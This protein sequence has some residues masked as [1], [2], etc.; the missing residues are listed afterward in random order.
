MKAATL[1]ALAALIGNPIKHIVVLMEENRSFDHLF[2]Y[3]KGSARPVNGLS[4]N[5]FNRLDTGDVTSKKI[6]VDNKAPYVAPCD[7]N[8][9]TPPTT[10]KIF[11]GNATAAGDLSN[12]A[13]L[14]FAEQES[15]AH[16]IDHCAVMSCF[17]PE[18]VPVLSALAE[19]FVLMDHFFA[20]HPGPTWPNRLYTLS[21]TSAGSTSTGSWYQ[22]KVGKL[23]PQ[24]TIFDQVAEAGLTWRNY[25]NDTPWELF[26][27]SLAHNT[28]NIKPL[29][30]F[31]DDARDGTLPSFSWINP[32]SGINTTTGVGSNDHHPDHDVAAGEAFY[33]DIYE[34]LRA[35]AAWNETLFIITY[36]EHGGFY[37]HVPTPTNVPSPGDADSHHSYPDKGFL[38]DRLGVRVPTLLISPWVQKGG[39]ISAPPA[40]QKPA[41]DSQYDLTSIMAS[42]RKLLEG[43]E[44][45]KPLTKRDAW[46]ATFEHAILPSST[47]MLAPRTDCAL[48]LPAAPPPSKRLPAHVEAAQPLNHLQ[49]DIVQIV[50]H[51]ATV[52]DDGLALPPPRLPAKQGDVSTYYQ[53]MLPTHFERTAAWHATHDDTLVDE[54]VLRV[55]PIRAAGGWLGSNWAA[56]HAAREG[57]GTSFSGHSTQEGV[58][59]V[60]SIA[61]TKID[62]TLCLTADALEGALVRSVP[63]YPSANATMNRDP[64]QWWRTQA[65]DGTLRPVANLSL[66][67]TNTEYRNLTALPLGAQEPVLLRLC[68]ERVEQNWAYHGNAPGALT[69]GGWM[70]FGD[71]LNALGVVAGAGG[72]GGGIGFSYFFQTSAQAYVKYDGATSKAVNGY[73]KP[74][75]TNNFPGIP[76][77]LDAALPNTDGKHVY[78]FKGSQ[79]WM[80]DL[81]QAKGLAGYP[82]SF[83]SPG[84]FPG[85]P[86]SPDA[87]LSHPSDGKSVY[88]FKGASYWKY[89]LA[90]GAMVAGYPKTYGAGTGRWSGIPADLNAAISHWSDGKSVYLF[91]GTQYYKY[92]LD[93]DALL[94]G[95]PRAY[96]TGTGHFEGVP[97]G[98]AAGVNRCGSS[99]PVQFGAGC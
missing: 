90:S 35:G 99:G 68:D 27:E 48:H 15:K 1:A 59:S 56:S 38:F 85:A 12:P 23:F 2:G 94:P 72:G 11:G 42:T 63:C 34:S 39:V 98:L 22:N 28:H 54:Y 55:R 5:E 80:Y 95:Y 87:A 40:A 46:S 19:E 78:F 24:R 30:Q 93:K 14:G 21:A 66:C 33:K 17:T 8:H 9:G 3:Y 45:T 61:G 32:R 91:K 81:L 18:R 25:Y 43:M 16:P 31:Y 64:R 20:A 26:M 10:R 86:T 88:F 77:G 69:N 44:H 70:Y 13:M 96:G 51:L 74:Y 92:D 71:A 49:E 52:A 97:A 7:P 73:P 53:T 50:E 47:G 67:A 37:D 83:P 41:P 60:Y 65:T 75:G 6:Y 79:F 76:A 58:R 84:N 29:S 82:R 36:D 62:G 4:G 57:T 89:D